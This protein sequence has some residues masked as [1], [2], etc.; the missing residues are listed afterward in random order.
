MYKQL[1]VSKHTCSC[2]T[3]THLSCGDEDGTDD[4][5]CVG[6]EPSQRSGHGRTHQVLADVEVDQCLYV[7]LQ[8]LPGDRRADKAT[9]HR[10]PC[11][12]S[13]RKQ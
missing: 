6:I 13:K 1:S 9:E 11:Q 10:I 2:Y 7:R 3:S 12:N 4:V 8:D 5:C